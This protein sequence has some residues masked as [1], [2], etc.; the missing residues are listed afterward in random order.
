MKRPQQLSLN[1]S[2][3]AGM[4]DPVATA[5]RTMPL[6]C[7]IGPLHSLNSPEQLPHLSI[8]F[9]S[10]SFAPNGS[11]LRLEQ[12]NCSAQEIFEFAV[13][14]RDLSRRFQRSFGRADCLKYPAV[15]RPCLQLLAGE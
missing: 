9:A 15:W 12:P 6:R 13:L 14:S 4:R 10:R 2:A 7:L 3:K 5:I 1:H 8:L 11:L